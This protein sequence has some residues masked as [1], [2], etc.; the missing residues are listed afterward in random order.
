MCWKMYDKKYRMCID[1]FEVL[2]ALK[3]GK[4]AG[5]LLDVEDM[6]TSDLQHAGMIM[7]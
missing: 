1:C 6:S 3:K 5:K 7:S 2:E 4:G